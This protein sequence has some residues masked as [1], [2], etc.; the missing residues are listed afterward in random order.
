MYKVEQNFSNQIHGIFV[1]NL[2][3]K[4][5]VNSDSLIRLFQFVKDHQDFYKTY[6]NRIDIKHANEMALTEYFKFDENNCCKSK[7]F[8]PDGIAYRREFFKA[9]LNAIL[10]LWL[11]TG[12]LDEPT[13]LAQ[14][15]Q[16]E[17]SE[18]S[19]VP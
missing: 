1:N 17:Y 8:F 9:G 11:N 14:I 12:C 4:I 5:Q 10:R 3:G 19:Y 13:M 15:I 2:T 18:R 7:T 16:K 6:F